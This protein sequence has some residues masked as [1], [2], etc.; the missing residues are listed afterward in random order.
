MSP[1]KLSSAQHQVLETPVARYIRRMMRDPSYITVF[2]RRYQTWMICRWFNRYSGIVVEELSVPR[3]LSITRTP[4]LTMRQLRYK[5][6]QEA[7]NFAAQLRRK[8][9][10]AARGGDLQEYQDHADAHIDLRRHYQRKARLQGDSPFWAM[11]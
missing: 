9:I 5:H 4:N 3:G 7:M 6:S 2:N 1:L 11:F 10:E 8:A